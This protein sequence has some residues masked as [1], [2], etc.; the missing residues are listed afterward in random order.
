MVGYIQSKLPPFLSIIIDSLCY[1][2]H[3][4]MVPWYG[5]AALWWSR[6]FRTFRQEFLLAYSKENEQLASTIYLKEIN[7]QH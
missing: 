3:Y 1:N 4:H 2:Y 5:L 6:A 7:L